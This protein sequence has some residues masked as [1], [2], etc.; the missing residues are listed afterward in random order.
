MQRSVSWLP[1]ADRNEMRVLCAHSEDNEADI[2]DLPAVVRH[3][4][5]FHCVSTLDEAL[6]ITLEP[7][8]GAPAER[9]GEFSGNRVA[10]CA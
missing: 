6:E 3:A 4:L 8:V 9:N 10:I 2:D 1:L 7:P 5:T